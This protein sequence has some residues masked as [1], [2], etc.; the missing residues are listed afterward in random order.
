M[1][2]SISQRKPVSVTTD[3]IV[4]T[5]TQ[6]EARSTPRDARRGMLSYRAP[7]SGSR[8]SACSSTVS[9]T[10]RILGE[11]FKMG[12]ATCE[13]KSIFKTDRNFK[14]RTSSQNWGQDVATFNERLKYCK[15]MGFEAP[16]KE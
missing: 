12:G 10:A 13:L 11:I 7:R 5:S 15:D 16:P 2:V 14:K 9:S 3:A 6:A 8:P 1:P 4:P